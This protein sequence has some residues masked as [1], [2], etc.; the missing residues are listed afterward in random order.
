LAGV[1]LLGER[2]NGQWFGDV[3]LGLRPVGVPQISMG[4]LVGQAVLETVQQGD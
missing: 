1:K 3:V 4:S 2:A